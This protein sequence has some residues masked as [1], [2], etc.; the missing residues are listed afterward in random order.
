M[1]DIRRR[2]GNTEMEYKGVGWE[3]RRLHSSGPE[4][5]EVAGLCEKLDAFSGFHKQPGIS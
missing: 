3:G 5:G 4:H 1:V 2:K